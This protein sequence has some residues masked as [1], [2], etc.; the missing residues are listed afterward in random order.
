MNSFIWT[1]D[2]TLSSKFCKRVI[3]KFDKDSRVRDGLVGLDKRID[4]TIKRSK[5]LKI[6]DHSDWI[7]EDKVF[8]NSIQKAI[9]IYQDYLNSTIPNHRAVSIFLTDKIYDDGYQIQRTDPGNFY[10]WHNDFYVEKNSIRVLT[11]IWYL[12]TLEKGGYTEFWD[13]TKIQPEQG[14]LM[15]FPSTWDFIHRGYPPESETKY[16]CTGWMYFQL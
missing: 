14:K 2:N 12:N 11:F 16:I 9:P 15:I 1:C 5:D 7:E 3:Q 8:F 13:G 6:S 10:T 4:P